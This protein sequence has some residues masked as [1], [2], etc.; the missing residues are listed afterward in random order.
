M[1][2]ILD[3]NVSF[4]ETVKTKKPVTENLY[5][6][7]T[8]GRYAERIERVRKE[9]APQKQKELKNAL[10]SFTPS[11]VFS[12]NDDIS[13]VF[14]SGF[15][16]IDID[17]KD[18][19]DVGNFDEMRTLIAQIPFVA[20]CG[21]SVRGEGYFCIIPIKYPDKHK[22]HFRSLQLNFAHCGVTIDESCSNVSRKRY[23]S[24]DE[25]FYYNS[26]AEVYSLT[27]TDAPAPHTGQQCFKS[28]HIT[29]VMVDELISMIEE[30]GIDITEKYEY[31]FAIGC[32]LANY[33]GES[34]R[35]RFHAVSQFHP[36]YSQNHTDEKFD[37]ALSGKYNYNITTFLYH[38]QR[39]GVVALSDFSETPKNSI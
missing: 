22:Q 17:K 19:M 31:W 10:P 30:R 16:C 29:P 33:F 12:E 32:S 38:A 5:N 2:R 1:K 8:D 27:I 26:D 9:S 3:V 35:E 4:Y 7:L 20:Y 21:L 36:G 39:M 34:G 25:D 24:H 28:T 13:L 11:G 37:D 15:I 14:H 23:V 18:N 6:L